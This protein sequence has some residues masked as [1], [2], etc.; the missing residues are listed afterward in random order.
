M[1]ILTNIISNIV[2]VKNI[3]VDETIEIGPSVIRV[4][5]FAFTDLESAF[6]VQAIGGATPLVDLH[7]GETTN[8]TE[9]N[10]RSISSVGDGTS[11]AGINNGSTSPI[12]EISL[13]DDSTA[14]TILLAADDISLAP[15]N[16]GNASL[17]IQTSALNNG[18]PTELSIA[19]KKYVDDNA[20]IPGDVN[21]FIDI[22]TTTNNITIAPDETNQSFIDFESSTLFINMRFRDGMT[23]TFFDQT[24]V[25]RGRLQV[26]NTRFDIVSESSVD[27]RLN[28]QAQDQV[29]LSR[30]TL[31]MNNGS[32]TALCVATKE[33][34]DTIV[35]KN[36][37]MLS[38]DSVATKEYVDTAVFELK[39][40]LE[41]K[42]TALNKGIES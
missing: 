28:V 25:Q 17:G 22:D 4:D 33:Y 10:I 39:E 37:G 40:Y 9:M 7:T 24:D 21:T 20:G 2:K 8:D 35:F 15:I 18:A 38:P 27:I 16:T 13:D 30:Q 19:T 11:K 5:A 42:I 36:N 31:T 3:T 12:S 14:T 26:D 34:V 1:T 23:P 29:I 6:V 32:P 41:E